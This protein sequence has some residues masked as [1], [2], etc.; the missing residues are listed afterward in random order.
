MNEPPKVSPIL[1]RWISSRS[2]AKKE[3]TSTWII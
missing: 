2:N 1:A 3:L